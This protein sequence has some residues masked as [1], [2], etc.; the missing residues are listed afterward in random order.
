M[1]K[2]SIAVWLLFSVCTLSAQNNGIMGNIRDPYLDN[3]KFQVPQIGEFMSRING[4]AV[5]VDHGDTLSREETLLSLFHK[6][7][8]LRDTVVTKA[9]IKGVIENP[10]KIHFEDTTWHA[11]VTC[12]INDNKG[13]DDKISLILRT[14]K[15]GDYLYKWV[16]SDAFGD[17]LDLKP[18]KSNPGLMISP[19]DNELEFPSLSFITNKESVNIVNYISAGNQIN[20]LSVFLTLIYNHIITIKSV[21]KV[22][23][24]FDDISGYRLVVDRYV[25]TSKNAGWLISDIQKTHV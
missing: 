20:S 22:Q 12:I 21:L 5:I 19:A 2:S 3:F 1:K 24:I 8:C 7:T 17:I 14:Q 16:I 15:R 11:V 18:Q 25:G 13:N 6:D 4:D 10:T 23:Y 9:F